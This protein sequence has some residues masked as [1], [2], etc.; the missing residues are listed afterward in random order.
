MP[1]GDPADLPCRELVEMVSGYL[2]GTLPAVQTAAVR[3]HLA[4]CEDC[5]TYVEQ[6]RTTVGLLG[7][8]CDD[9]LPDELRLRLRDSYRA[10]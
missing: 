7:Q 2:E 6:M 4:E 10:R 1:I 9:D 8:L 5:T 3:A